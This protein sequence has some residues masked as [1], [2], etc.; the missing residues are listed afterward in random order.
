MKPKSSRLAVL[1]LMRCMSSLASLSYLPCLS[2]R[3]TPFCTPGRLNSSTYQASR[4][5]IPSSLRVLRSRGGPC[6]AAARRC[7]REASRLA[8]TLPRAAARG[9]RL[10]GTTSD[11]SSRKPRSSSLAILTPRHEFAIIAS[12]HGAEYECHEHRS[13]MAAD[14]PALRR[15]Q[16]LRHGGGA[17]PGELLVQQRHHRPGS[18]G[19]HPPG[20][21]GQTLP[22]PRV[23]RGYWRRS[24]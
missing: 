13:A 8:A 5:A 17:R 16:S 9:S 2:L 21:G 10:S 4:G 20:V 3:N 12:D 19:G 1:A 6:S 11:I 18:A 7:S 14:L 15:R 23:R 22:V 24:R